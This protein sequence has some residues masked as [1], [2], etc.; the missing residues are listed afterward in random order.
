MLIVGVWPGTDYNPYVS[1]FVDSLTNAGITAKDV[2]HP[3]KAIFQRMDLFHIHWPEKVFWNVGKV[4]GAFSAIGVLIGLLLLKGKGTKIVWCVHNLEPHDRGPRFMA[5]WCLYIGIVSMLIDGFVTLSPSTIGLVRRHL[6]RLA[7]K[8]GTFIWHPEYLIDR[9]LD[10]A[11]WRSRNGI[12]PVDKLFAFVG[13]IRR[14]KGVE[15]LVECFS[16]TDDPTHRLLVAGATWDGKTRQLLESSAKRDDRIIL[17]IGNLVESE[18]ASATLSA[19]IVILPFKK[20]FH[21]GT[22][23]YA[24]SCGKPVCTPATAYATDLRNQVG[25]DWVQ[26]YQGDITPEVFGN[27]LISNEVAKPS[28][29]FLSIAESG[30]KIRRFYISLLASR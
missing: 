8:P 18:F 19:D 26:L 29:E 6:P 12:A 2:S 28:L 17:K 25:D 4:R 23:I 1:R 7:N 21:S 20:Y 14:Y 13:Q 30:A 16:R 24:L 27:A 11:E 5:V 3:L 9:S 10:C 15:E 22:I